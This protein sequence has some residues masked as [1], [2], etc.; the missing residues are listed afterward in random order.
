MNMQNVINVCLTICVT[1]LVFQNQQ[2]KNLVENISSKPIG[3]VDALSIRIDK[4]E[5]DLL[6]YY[7]AQSKD[8]TLQDLRKL[9][10]SIQKLDAAQNKEIAILTGSMKRLSKPISM[11]AIKK[12]IEKCEVPNYSAGGS[13]ATWNHGHKSLEC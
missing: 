10:S 12:I 2:L 6:S 1:L 4:V 13:S 5:A 7:G 8:T 9:V 11:E 3:A